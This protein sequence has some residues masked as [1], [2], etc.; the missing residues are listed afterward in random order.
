MQNKLEEIKLTLEKPL[1]ITEYELENEINKT[2]V[3]QQY[4]KL[5]RKLNKK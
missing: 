1:K 5:L 3:T 2:D 4:L